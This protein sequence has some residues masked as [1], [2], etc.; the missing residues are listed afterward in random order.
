[1]KWRLRYLCPLMLAGCGTM[2]NLDGRDRPMLDLPKQS[3]TTL[4]GG[5]SRDV[6]WIGEG[7][8]QYAA[9]V[10]LSMIGEV[11]TAPRVITQKGTSKGEW[12]PAGTGKRQSTEDTAE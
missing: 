6:K 5:V 11:V 2:A 9:D 12:N 10:P 4:F 1:V 7:M 3:P 8:I